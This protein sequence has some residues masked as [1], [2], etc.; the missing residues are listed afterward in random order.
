M[1]RQ[2]VVLTK[3]KLQLINSNGVVLIY[4]GDNIVVDKLLESVLNVIFSWGLKNV[5]CKKYLS[6]ID[7]I[8]AEKLVIYVHQF[9][10]THSCAGLLHWSIGGA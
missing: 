7:V 1:S 2:R 9:A 3:F 8:F 5:L 10:L 4:D 6:H